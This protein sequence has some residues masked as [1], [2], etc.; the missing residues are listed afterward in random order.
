MMTLKIVVVGLLVCI[1]QG[2][3]MTAH[4]VA[5]NAETGA[6]QKAMDE[7]AIQYCGIRSRSVRG[8]RSMLIEGCFRQ[9]TGRFPGEMGIGAHDDFISQAKPHIPIASIEG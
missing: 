3:P 2:M 7:C 9:K 8:S 1:F 6:A 4:A 5:N